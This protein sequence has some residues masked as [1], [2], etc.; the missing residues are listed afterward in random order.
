MAQIGRGW[1]WEDYVGFKREKEGEEKGE[2]WCEER[3]SSFER[4]EKTEREKESFSEGGGRIR[5]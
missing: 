2:S 3:C 1:C 4:D 5:V